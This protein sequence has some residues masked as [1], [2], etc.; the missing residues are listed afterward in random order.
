[1]YMRVHTQCAK[2]TQ[3]MQSMLSFLWGF[4]GMH[5]PEKQMLLRLNLEAILANNTDHSE[6]FDIHQRHS[7]FDSP[8]QAS[9]IRPPPSM[10]G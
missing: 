9:L 1:M 3:S 2:C 4:G 6:E 10:I 8:A 7:H 5:P